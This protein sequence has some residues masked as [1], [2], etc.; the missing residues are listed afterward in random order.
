MDTL[1]EMFGH[2]L[3]ANLR[4]LDACEEAGERVLAASA[5]GTYGE[6]GAALVHLL[7]AEERYVA[8]LTGEP[9]PEPPLSERDAFPGFARLRERAERSGEAL[10]GL[11]MDD[12]GET[13]LEGENR[14]GPY[15][16]RALVPLVQAIHHANEHRTH[17]TTALSQNEVEPP[18][19]S[20]WLYGEE[21]GYAT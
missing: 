16:I 18:E 17:V 19:L 9:Q 10:I 21:K 15:S 11:A 2:N 12:P 7:A 1:T 6:V 20:A 3:W 14:F 5:D 8:L 13:L 4:L